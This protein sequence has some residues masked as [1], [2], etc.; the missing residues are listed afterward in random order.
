[1]TVPRLGHRFDEAL[2]W[3]SELHRSQLRKGTDIPYLSHLLAVASLVLEDGGDE[4]E[5]IAALL[6]DA[7]EDTDVT[8]ADVEQRFGRPVAAIVEACTDADV[9]PKPPWRERKRRYVE[10]LLE[11]S[12]PP[13]A[14]RVSSADKLHNARC[15][16]AD[17]RRVGPNLWARF[18]PDARSAAA[19]LGYYDSLVAA[20]RARRPD[21]PLTAELERVVSALHD[22]VDRR[23]SH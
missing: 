7:V 10:H 19:Q 23:E 22:E 8:V 16:L 3:A 21:S 18:N 5:A 12:T 1:M 2:G 17:Y 9:R 20:F 6:H 4:D 11:E 13:G 14:L 15:I